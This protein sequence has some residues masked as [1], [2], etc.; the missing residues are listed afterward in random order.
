M[1]DSCGLVGRV[2]V[3]GGREEPGGVAWHGPLASVAVVVLVGV[4]EVR[5]GGASRGG[6]VVAVVRDA[7]V[8]GVVPEDARPR[9]CRCCP[10]LCFFL[11]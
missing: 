1:A 10:K 11:S 6:L 7:V 3:P 2:D 8:V 5:T 9:H 4:R